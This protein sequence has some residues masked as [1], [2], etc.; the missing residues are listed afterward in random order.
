MAGKIRRAATDLINRIAW[1]NIRFLHDDARRI[2]VLSEE[3]RTL[4]ERNNVLSDQLANQKAESNVHLEA[5]SK[6]QQDVMKYMNEIDQLRNSTCWKLTA[7]LRNVVE[8]VRRQLGQD[9]K[10]L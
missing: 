9:G 10:T 1:D 3:L 6:S 2:E 8:F 4:T 5:L 7:P